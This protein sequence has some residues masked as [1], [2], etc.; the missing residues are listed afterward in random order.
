MI[1]AA[2]AGEVFPSRAREVN[3]LDLYQAHANI[4]L[5]A[6]QEK[7]TARLGRQEI[8]YGSARLMMAPGWANRRRTHDGVRF[9]YESQDWEVNPFWVRP[10]LDFMTDLVDFDISKVL[11]DPDVSQ[12]VTDQI[13]GLMDDIRGSYAA[14]QTSFTSEA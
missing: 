7:L 2:S 12:L 1:D 10:G 11:D 5:H 6:G 4:V 13:S 3:R 9:I 14:S 8:R